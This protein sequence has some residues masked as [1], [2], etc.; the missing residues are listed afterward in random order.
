[1][2]ESLRSITQVDDGMTRDDKVG[3]TFG[4]DGV[5]CVVRAPADYIR[6]NFGMQPVAVHPTVVR[7]LA[8]G[9]KSHLRRGRTVSSVLDVGA[10]SETQEVSDWEWC[11]LK[12][13]LPVAWAPLSTIRMRALEV[14]YDR[15][16]AG[17]QYTRLT[18]I[19]Q[20]FPHLD[21]ASASFAM[22]YLVRAGYLG[23][24]TNDNC[25]IS[26]KGIEMIEHF[27]QVIPGSAIG[28]AIM[29]FRK[30]TQ[31]LWEHGVAPAFATLGLTPIRVDAE[32]V[33]DPV[34]EA[35]YDFIRRSDLVVAD[36]TF[37]RPNCY[38]EV[39]MAHA[40]GKRMALT[41]REQEH[42]H[43]DL[44]AYHVIRWKAG[45]WDSFRNELIGRGRQLLR[46]AAFPG[47][48]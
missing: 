3:V 34:I 14:A 1:M 46:S 19:C 30:E 26:A 15:T 35:I 36:L 23:R 28:F 42:L 29:A 47:T 4:V 45:D 10:T 6:Q 16:E 24:P 21:P 18:D 13:G 40:L 7:W 39:G 25:S 37:A 27:R 12:T 38:Y 33:T 22:E 5:K 41:A 8:K 31:D 32:P 20:T 44:Q 11:R 2:E 9:L 17:A 43:F 48:S